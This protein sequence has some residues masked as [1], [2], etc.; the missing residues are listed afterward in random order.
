MVKMI[1]TLGAVLLRTSQTKLASSTDSAQETD[2][3]QAAEFHAFIALWTGF[4]DAAYAFVATNMREF[5]VC[6]WCALCTCGSAGFGMQVY[7]KRS[8]SIHD[9]LAWFGGCRRT[10]LADTCIEHLSQNLVVSG[11]WNWVVGHEFNC[12]AQ[13]PDHCHCLYC[14]D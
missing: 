12:T 9:L 10:T 2:S 4:N 1:C 8:L 5:D 14:W 3:D 13:F 7:T 6:D 11:C